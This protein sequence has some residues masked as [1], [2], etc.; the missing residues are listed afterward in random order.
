MSTTCESVQHEAALAFLY[1]RIDYERATAVAYGERAYKLDRMHD[2]LARLGNPQ[3]GMPIV[4][5]AGTKGKGSTAAMSAAVL[6]AAGYKTGLF[7]SPHL[8]R[9]EERM[10]VDGRACPP[11]EF[12]ALVDVLRPIVADMD[13]AAAH[14]GGAEIGP[15]Y[16][17][18]TTALAFLHFAREGVDA[19]VL[20]V[21][22]GGRLDSTNVCRPAVSVITSI[23]Y[24]H[25]RQLGN[26]LSAIAREKAGIIKP[27]VPV[28]SGVCNDEPRRVIEEVSRQQGA[29]LV[30]LGVDFDVAYRPPM[31]LDERAAHG[32]IDY[33]YHHAGHERR[34][35][36]VS[37]GLLGRHQA[38]NAAVALAALEEL[39]QQGWRIDESAI[40]RG[41][42]EL[43]WP[44]RVEIVGR[45]PTVVIDAAHNVA[46][47]AAL[48]ET[49]AES[50]TARRR[51]LVFATTKEKDARGMLDLVLPRFDR[52]IFTRYT[53]NPRSVPP[54]EL[55]DLAQ[56]L[57]DAN[58]RLQ[59]E[60]TIA[61]DPTAAWSEVHELAERN[62][63]VCIT[64]SFFIAAQLRHEMEQRPLRLG[65]CDA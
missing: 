36:G 30:E 34:L 38:A 41:L 42:A 37:L 6:T 61:V 9:I 12:A 50:I 51:I 59:T 7:S 64:G 56:E 40:R 62:D 33:R 25:M 31:H 21:G 65:P 58:D 1:G 49:L 4:H 60:C 3:A 44:A 22:M 27:G 10:A 48:M 5:V 63:L 43:R 32:E 13:A 14:V 24:D 57:A 45:Q 20:E 35:N 15:T 29:R 53:N 18:L 46:S 47:V 2:L 23:S 28:V 16:F 26:T 54:E 11:A 8:D 19:A 17:E 55:Y 52:V 39:M